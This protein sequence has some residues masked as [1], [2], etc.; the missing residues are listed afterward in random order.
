MTGNPCDD[1][2]EP[3]GRRSALDR[4]EQHFTRW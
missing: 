1:N 2:G 4:V 3:E